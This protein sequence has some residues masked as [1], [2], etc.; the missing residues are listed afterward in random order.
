MTVQSKRKRQRTAR[1]RG[2]KFG[3]SFSLVTKQEGISGHI[4]CTITH[5]GERVRFAIG[6]NR[7]PIEDWDTK[8]QERRGSGLDALATNERIRAVKRLITQALEQ[9][10]SLDSIQ[11]MATGT[12][13]IRKTKGI[14]T[15]YERF[16]SARTELAPATVKAFNVSLRA[17]EAYETHTEPITLNTFQADSPTARNNARTIVKDLTNWLV[18]EYGYND[19]T[20]TKALRHLQ[21]V[22]RWHVS[23]GHSGAMPIN[24]PIEKREPI[25]AREMPALTK[26][27][28]EA[29]WNLDLPPNQNLWHCRNGFVLAC[30]TGQRY[31]DWAKVD[32][33]KWRE[34]YQVISQQKTGSA[35][36][37]LHTEEVRAVLRLYE[38]TGWPPCIAKITNSAIVNEF[39]KVVC[40]MAGINRKVPNVVRKN[41]RDEIGPEHEL[42]DVV[43]THTARRTFVTIRQNE[44][45]SNYDIME[46]TGHKSEKTMKGYDRT[47]AEQFAKRY[48]VTEYKEK[49]QT[50]VRST[51]KGA[52]SK[53]TKQ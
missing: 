15:L 12:D 18:N 27:D 52:K 37:V 51:A 39:I 10:K 9:G 47:T 22:I 20:T 1:I 43:S 53:R 19:N 31:S 30:H 24:V 25:E 44:G 46:R 42:C 13:T 8:I 7:I 17:M 11:A 35:T 29:L 33:T 16:L 26:E 4:L 34:A 38:A 28:V 49:K 45:D 21:T 5:K 2:P 48:G 23:E 6:Q 3:V 14:R 32:P 40:K 36:R 50:P 41:G